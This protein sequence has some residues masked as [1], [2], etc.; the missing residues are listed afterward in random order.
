M[1]VNKITWRYTGTDDSYHIEMDGEEV[2]IAK[3][4]FDR[5]IFIATLKA[6]IKLL[7]SLG[8]CHSSKFVISGNDLRLI[9]DRKE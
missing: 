3:T 6:N 5:D 9:T 1:E 4:A 8:Y 7:D 2:H